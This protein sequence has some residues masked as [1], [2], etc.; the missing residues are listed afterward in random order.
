MC[1]RTDCELRVAAEVVETVT[2]WNRRLV[3]EASEL[4]SVALRGLAMALMGEG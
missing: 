1:M 2:T 3:V 4:T